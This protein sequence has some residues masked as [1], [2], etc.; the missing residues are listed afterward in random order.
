L[1]AWLDQ[2]VQ[3]QNISRTLLIEKL[4]LGAMNDEQR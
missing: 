4:I 1:V 2:Q 3:N